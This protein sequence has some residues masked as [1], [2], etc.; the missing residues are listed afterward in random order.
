MVSLG[1]DRPSLNKIK[2]ATA[3]TK[4]KQATTTKKQRDSL[5]SRLDLIILPFSL[6]SCFLLNITEGLI[7][8][9]L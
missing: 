7:R 3:T 2:T 5:C 1:T 6:M 9:M 4:T 8:M